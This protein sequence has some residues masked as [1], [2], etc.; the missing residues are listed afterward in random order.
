MILYKSLKI[1]FLIFLIYS[2]LY[3]DLFL[4]SFIIHSESSVYSKKDITELEN[5]ISSLKQFTPIIY[6]DLDEVKIY[7]V[8]QIKE[9]SSRKI[10]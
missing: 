6:E 4:N 10:I 7:D 3:F 1:F 8:L 2:F 9:K 5:T